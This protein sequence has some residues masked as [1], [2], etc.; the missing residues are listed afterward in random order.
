LYAL[1]K[2]NDYKWWEKGTEATVFSYDGV[3]FS[4]PICFEDIFG[5]LNATF[6]RNGADMLVNLTN[7]SWSGSVP[8]EMQHLGLAVF[9]AVE[10]RRPLIRGTNSGITCLVTPS[11]KI[12]DRWSRSPKDG[13]CTKCP[14]AEAGDDV[15]HPLPRSVRLSRDGRIRRAFSSLPLSIAVRTNG[16]AGM[17]ICSMRVCSGDVNEGLALV[18]KR[19]AG[20][21]R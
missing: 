7:D 8:A 17:T 15:L 11:G 5:S 13:G 12:I 14:G 18:M 10:N 2:A 3:R 1:L 9:R 4:T 20:K 19:R 6:V 21:R 16:E